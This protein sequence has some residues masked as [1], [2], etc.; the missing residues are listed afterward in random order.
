MNQF[1]KQVLPRRTQALLALITYM[2]QDFLGGKKFIKLSWAVNLH[3]GLTF[4]FVLVLMLLTRNFSAPAWLYLA[5]HGGYG[6]VWLLKDRAFP[7]RRWELRVTLGGA[8]LTF[9]ALGT[10]WIAPVLLI[11]GWGYAAPRVLSGWQTCLAVIL[12]LLGI[13]SMTAADAQKAFTLAAKP[14]LITT[15]MFSKIR[16]PNYLGEMSIYAGFAVCAGHWLPW[17]VLAGWW[18]GVFRVYM[19][20]IDASLS[21]YPGWAEYQA[22]TGMI[23]PRLFPPRPRKNPGSPPPE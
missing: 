4:L 13:F 2:S 11:T 3:K 10:Y 14:G 21:R 16:H 12:V 1:E 19:L 6:I 23:F 7:D 18:L 15:G 17:L 22:R 20:Q 8:L 9:L 5:L